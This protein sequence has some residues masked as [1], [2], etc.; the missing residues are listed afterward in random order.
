MIVLK[1]SDWQKFPRW[2]FVS[3]KSISKKRRQS[4]NFKKIWKEVP[5][6]VRTRTRRPKNRLTWNLY[7]WTRRP[8]FGY[9]N[10]K[11]VCIKDLKLVFSNSIG[12]DAG[13]PRWKNV[14]EE[15]QAPKGCRRL[16]AMGKPRTIRWKKCPR[17]LRSRVREEAGKP[18]S[19]PCVHKSLA[20]RGPDF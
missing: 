1:I 10:L 14:A 16:A 5:Y 6:N 8:K 17:A 9:R 19:W 15:T 12:D 18:T 20:F 4:C 7:A 2:R 3:V 13:L 11:F